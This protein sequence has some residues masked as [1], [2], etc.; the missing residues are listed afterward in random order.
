MTYLDVAFIFGNV[1]ER[2]TVKLCH[3]NIGNPQTV[4]FID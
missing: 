3:P 4:L 2:W 1:S